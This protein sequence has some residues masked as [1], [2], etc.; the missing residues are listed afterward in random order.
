MALL[1]VKNNV[2]LGVGPLSPVTVLRTVVL[3]RTARWTTLRECRRQ[4]ASLAQRVISG[5]M[6]RVGLGEGTKVLSAHL[7][8][9]GLL[10]SGLSLCASAGKRALRVGRPSSCG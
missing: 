1:G 4:R 10:L 2:L 3:Q 6:L 8:V 5:G 9:V 7:S